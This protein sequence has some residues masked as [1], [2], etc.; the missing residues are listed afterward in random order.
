MAACDKLWFSVHNFYVSLK[1][2]NT[3]VAGLLLHG[4]NFICNRA[5]SI[6]VLRAPLQNCDYTART[7]CLT[8]RMLLRLGKC[9]SC[10]DKQN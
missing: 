7:R 5:D 2:A 3:A 9:V 10:M 4:V 8:V 1:N 6:G